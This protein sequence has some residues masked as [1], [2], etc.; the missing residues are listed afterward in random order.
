MDHATWDVVSRIPISNMV[1]A[2]CQDDEQFDIH[3]TVRPNFMDSMALMPAVNFST[4]IKKNDDKHH[5]FN[6]ALPIE[7]VQNFEPLEINNDLDIQKQQ[8]SIQSPIHAF[9]NLDSEDE[10][11]AV[12]FSLHKITFLSGQNKIWAN[13][14]NKLI[15][16]NIELE[17]TNTPNK[18]FGIIKERV[19]DYFDNNKNFNYT[20][21]MS[22]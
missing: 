6:S 11:T 2:V 7:S 4:P 18:H 13:K 5:R 1:S 20:S 3:C 22:I 12:I 19:N 16:K 17:N 8:N 15:N 10:E 9:P 14:I 21:V